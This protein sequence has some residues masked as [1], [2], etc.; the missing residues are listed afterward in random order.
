MKFPD[1][2]N[3]ERKFIFTN[4]SDEDFVGRWEYTMTTI[5]A[6]ESI[7]LPMYKA[8]NFC[9]HFVDREMFK[10]PGMESFVSID[11]KRVPFEEKTIME[12]GIGT[13]SPA[14]QSLKDKIRA[15]IE[16]E[17]KQDKKETIEEGENV[18]DSTTESDSNVEFSELNEPVENKPK[19]GR[20]KTK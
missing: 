11:E 10:V 1:V 13:D 4:W 2:F 5:K 14:L 19:R 8:Y 12:I 15:E 16:A 18:E 3:N 6:G 20:P 17:N 7:E 9:K